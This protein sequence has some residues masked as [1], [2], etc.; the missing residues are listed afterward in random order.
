[1]LQLLHSLSEKTF[2]KE[3]TFRTTSIP[4]D[5]IKKD[6]IKHD[7]KLYNGLQVLQKR[8]TEEA[9]EKTSLVNVFTTA[10]FVNYLSVYRFVKNAT[11]PQNTD[12]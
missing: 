3:T 6:V 2:K 1:M 11:A 12:A 4:K 5:N 8:C 10:V 9:C 7:V